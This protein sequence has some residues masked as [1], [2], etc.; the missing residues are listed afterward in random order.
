MSETGWENC[1]W[2]YNT[3]Y[4]ALTNLKLNHH[5]SSY[6]QFYRHI[7]IRM[8]HISL[9]VLK[10]FSIVILHPIH[11]VT[12]LTKLVACPSLENTQTHL[13]PKTFCLSQFLLNFVIFF[14]K[15]LHHFWQMSK[16]VTNRWPKA[17]NSDII[18]LW[19]HYH[20]KE[21]HHF[22]KKK[23]TFSHCF[24]VKRFLWFMSNDYFHIT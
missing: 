24:Q 11:P 20:L 19:F 17:P 9:Y 3:W 6:V 4:S 18:Y 8:H 22:F 7:N 16:Y 15:T 1:K 5:F 23:Y 21:W 14:S 12:I 13:E 10:Y 2:I